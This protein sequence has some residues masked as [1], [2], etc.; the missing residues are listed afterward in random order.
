M[1]T[2]AAFGLLALLGVAGTTGCATLRPAAA[3]S[4]VER[5]VGA[6]TPRSIHW[7]QGTPADRE[8]E[9]RI[10]ALLASEL[11]PEAAVQI[12]LFNNRSL[13]ATFGRLGIAQA[14]LV[15]ADNASRVGRAAPSARS[16]GREGR[17]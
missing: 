3:F 11:T 12:A 8:A 2:R 6:R 4:D 5:L 17:A 7:N 14:D 13:Q 15:H 16:R 10:D 1:D 9:Q